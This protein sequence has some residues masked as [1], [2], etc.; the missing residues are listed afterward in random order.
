MFDLFKN[1]GSNLT[2][3]KATQMAT[4]MINQTAPVEMA[5]KNVVAKSTGWIFYYD[6]AEAVKTGNWQTYGIPGNNALFVGKDGT[7]RFIPNP[8]DPV[9]QSE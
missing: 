3:E 5:I 8:N 7:T 2:I 9:F 1:S 6:S 4:Q